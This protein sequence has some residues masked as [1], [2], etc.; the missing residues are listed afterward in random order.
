MTHSQLSTNQNRRE[1]HE[2]ADSSREFVDEVSTVS[3]L[4]ERQSK[5]SKG[6]V[7]VNV[8]KSYLRLRWSWGGKRYVFSLGL[9]DSKINRV[10]AERKAKLIER[11]I[12]TE[13]FD[14]ILEKYR[15]QVV[16]TPRR[17][18]TGIL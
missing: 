6:S 15:I 13:Q 1:P 5:S 14:P 8:D 16:D 3:A 9:L 7:V 12:L 2:A 17:E 11:D 10:V 18:R 4:A